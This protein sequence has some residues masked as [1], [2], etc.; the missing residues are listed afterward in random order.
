MKRP[1]GGSYTASL[2]ARVVHRHGRQIG[3]VAAE[4][5]RRRGV[6][7]GIAAVSRLIPTNLRLLDDP[8]AARYIARQRD[9]GEVTAAY[10]NDALSSVHR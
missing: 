7:L 6:R 2:A 1:G 8:L 9:S 5:L 3:I 4:L 10:R